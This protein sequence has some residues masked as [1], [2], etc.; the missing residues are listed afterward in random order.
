MIDESIYD[1]PQDLFEERFVWLEEKVGY[2]NYNV[3]I[4]MMALTNKI[5]LLRDDG[6]S[7]AKVILERKQWGSRRTKE[8][9]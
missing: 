8:E 2:I 5:G 3:C 9:F 7:N 1:N 4:L 6:G